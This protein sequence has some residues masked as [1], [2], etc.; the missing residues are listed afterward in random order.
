MANVKEKNHTIFGNYLNRE[1]RTKTELVPIKVKN[2]V[3]VKNKRFFVSTK[4]WLHYI[5]W[6][7]NKKDDDDA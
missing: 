3:K 5:L 2:I 6:W 7:H 1:Q 4:L